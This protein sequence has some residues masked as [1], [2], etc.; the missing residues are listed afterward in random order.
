LGFYKDG[1][2]VPNSVAKMA[3]TR[4]SE[5]G[6]VKR[7]GKVCRILVDH[8]QKEKM[9]KGLYKR[10]PNGEKFAEVIF[11]SKR[12]KQNK[13]KSRCQSGREKFAPRGEE[14]GRG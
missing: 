8:L 12:K 3:W 6:W 4:F 13:G 10:W 5:G 1:N 7:G 11:V 9:P 2:L 14:K